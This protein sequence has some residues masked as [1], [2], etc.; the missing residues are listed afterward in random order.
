[1]QRYCDIGNNFQ[2]CTVTEVSL[3]NIIC[4]ML[5]DFKLESEMKTI[6]ELR[7]AH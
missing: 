3:E 5:A 4:Y 1:M 7:I 2:N 6:C